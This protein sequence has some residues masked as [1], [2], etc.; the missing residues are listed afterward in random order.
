MREKSEGKPVEIGRL[1]RFAT[2]NLM[3]TGTHPF[4][5][6]A[7]THKHIA[8]I[9]AGP[10]GLS[11]AHR[12]AM[13]GHEVTI[14]DANPKAG[15]LNEF[16]IAAYKTTHDFAQREI[17]WLLQIGGISIKH[18]Q[19]LGQDFT[20]GEV[21]C[22]YD[23]VFLGMGLG[24]VRHLGIE[25]EG[26]DNIE[27]AVDFIARL[28]Q[29]KNLS[30][31][32]TGARVVIIGG[33]MTAIDAAVQAK[34]LGAPDVTIIYRGSA[35]KMPASQFE[36]E[37][38]KVKNVRVIYNTQPIAFHG[39][40]KVEAIECSTDTHNGTSIQLPADHVLLAIG[41]IL[42][43]LPARLETQDNKIK[44]NDR[45]RTSMTG[46][47]AGGDCVAIGDDLTVTAVAQGR[48]AAMD[49]HAMLTGV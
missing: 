27:N 4:T 26:L 2:D 1:Q 25:G 5:R 35:E 23:A 18:S 32:E 10:A 40:Q 12:L 31:L 28:R 41:Q 14:F 42:A 44:I 39:T 37:L 24:D 38:A 7:L 17:D 46:V 45:Y 47:W 13:L 29:S 15:G 11:A 30:Q 21:N 49:I 3:D 33:G 22:D 9:G 20:L 43:R 8:V 6:A 19:I 34:L 36:Q 16:G 48:D